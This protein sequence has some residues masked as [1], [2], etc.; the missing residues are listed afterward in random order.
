MFKDTHA[1]LF[2][3][4]GSKDSCG[5]NS[6]RV[7]SRAKAPRLCGAPLDKNYGP[8]AVQI[9]RRFGRAIAREVLRSGD[10]NGHGLRESS[11]DQSGIWKIARV[12]G[13]I[14]A[15]LDDRGRDF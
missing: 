13:Q 14:E 5:D 15:V 10:E 2:N 12:N 6:L 4:A 3:I 1:H 9:V 8:K 7:W 11:R